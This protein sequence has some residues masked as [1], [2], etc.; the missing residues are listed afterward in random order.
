MSLARL[1]RL[2]GPEVPPYIVVLNHKMDLVLLSMG[3]IMRTMQDVLGDLA[4][5]KSQ[6]DGLVGLNKNLRD[7]VAEALAGTKIP[8]AVQ[9]QIDAAFDQVETNK[10][11]IM[12]AIN[13]GTAAHGVD[14]TAA[15]PAAAAG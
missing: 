10:A 13:E 12:N 7:Q 6:I 14:P 2:Y 15:A 3:L 4:D 8:D 5:E 11:A 9:A 1:L